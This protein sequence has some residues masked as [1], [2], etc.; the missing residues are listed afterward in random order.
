MFHV[1]GRSI[2]LWLWAIG[3]MAQCLDHVRLGSWNTKHLGRDNFAYREAS[4][5][6]ANLDLIALQE[7]NTT[8]AGR[9]ALLALQQALVQRT[10]DNWCSIISPVP[11][12]ARERYAFLWRESAVAFGQRAEDLQQ[13]SCPRAAESA[14]L[15]ITH[16]AAIVREPA[17]AYF[18]AKEDQRFF[19][20]ASIHLVPT[21][22]KPEREVP[23]LW[24]S[25]EATRGPQAIVAL[26]AGDF[27]LASTHPSFKVWRDHHWAAALPGKVKTSLK[28]KQKAFSQAYDNVWWKDEENG[29]Q[30][31][32]QVINPYLIFPEKSA[33]EIYR[34]LSDHAPIAVYYRSVT[35][36]QVPDPGEE[37]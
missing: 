24:Q 28:Q 13:A 2:L 11:S 14:A 32:Y 30:M 16:E 27:N 18:Y 9:Q 3:G 31:S 8:P 34:V 23:F 19:Y 6:L 1:L 15:Q 20:L 22:K 35:P 4:A 29:C 5:L 36:P 37:K 33:P 10:K 26:V 25:M 21:A 7:V 12:G 17:G